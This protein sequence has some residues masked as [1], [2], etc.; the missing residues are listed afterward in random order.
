M[1]ER[2]RLVAEIDAGLKRLVSAEQTSNREIVEEALWQYLGGA[3]ASNIER[4]IQDIED[5]VAALD[6]EAE[7]I[8]HERAEKERKLETLKTELERMEERDT[9]ENGLADLEDILDDGKNVDPGHGK[10]EKVANK[11]GRTPEQVIEDLKDRNP[12]LPDDR[13]D[14]R[15]SY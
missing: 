3:K 5:T 15:R 8:E 9:Y 6:R 12:D 2:E 14:E 1:S 10:V 13:F 11:Y 7:S 4:R